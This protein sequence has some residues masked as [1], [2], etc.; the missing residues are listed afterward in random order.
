LYWQRSNKWREKKKQRRNF[1]RNHP[2]WPVPYLLIPEF[3]D[4]SHGFAGSIYTVMVMD[5]PAK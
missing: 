3:M 5:I 1:K 2:I 4:E